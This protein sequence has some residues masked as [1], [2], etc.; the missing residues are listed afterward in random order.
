MDNVLELARSLG[1][2]LKSSE[3][4]KALTEIENKVKNDKDAS[5]ALKNFTG[6]SAEIQ[7]KE[8]D[9]QPVEVAEKRELADLETAVRENE[10]LRGMMQAQADYAEMI[11]RVNEAIFGALKPSEDN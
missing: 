10:L 1:D 9:L 11:N 5:D 2:A 6:K 3:R 7:R 4:F 8:A